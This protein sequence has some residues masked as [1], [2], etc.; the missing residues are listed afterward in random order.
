MLTDQTLPI[1]FDEEDRQANEHLMRCSLCGE[2]GDVHLFYSGEYDSRPDE[3]RT[4]I[5]LT[6][7]CYLCGGVFN[8]DFRQHKG[9]TFVTVDD[10]GQD[11]F[12]LSDKLHGR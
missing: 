12:E 9:M 6:F 4:S 5:V 2:T 11:A 1:S 10:A 8:V 3:R 7:G